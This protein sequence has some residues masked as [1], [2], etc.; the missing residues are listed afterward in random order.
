MV[1]SQVELTK[2]RSRSVLMGLI[3]FRE[4]FMQNQRNSQTT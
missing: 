2:S 4:T 1:V 3:V